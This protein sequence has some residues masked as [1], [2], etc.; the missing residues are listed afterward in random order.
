MAKI[1]K[2]QRYYIFIL[3]NITILF[4]QN[5]KCGTFRETERHWKNKLSK[6]VQTF[7]TRP[8][9]QK[10][11]L[12]TNNKIRIHYDTIGNNQ[13]AMV[14]DFGNRIPNSYNLFI[15]TLVSIVDSVWNAEIDTYGFIAPPADN[16][17]GGGDE[18]DFYIYD[19]QGGTF[20]QTQIEDDL[21][22]GQAKVN[23]Q[24]ASF[25]EMDNDFGVGY[26]TKGVKA[27]MATTAHEF[28]HAIQVGGSGVWDDKYFY[29]YEL[30]AEA[31]ENIVFR[32]AKD[33]IFDISKYFA[34]ISKIPLFQQ[35]LS[36]DDNTIDTPGYERALWGMFLMKKYG[37]EIMKAI[38]DEMKNM[39]PVQS[40]QNALNSF[41]SSL[42]R[43]FADF[44][45]WNYHTGYRS[46]S[47]KYYTD[48]GLFPMVSFNLPVNVTATTRDISFTS[49]SFT[50]NYIKA[51]TN[52]DSAFVMVSNTN[53]VDA[54]NYSQ[55]IFPFKLSF[56]SSSSS[57]LPA[58]SKSIY[59]KL[60]VDDY[61]EWSY[62]AISTT[63]GPLCFPNPFNPLSSSLL[64][65]LQGIQ[66]GSKATLNIYSASSMDL[67][68][69]GTPHY[70]LFSGT[71]YAEWSGR[72]NSGQTASSGIYIFVL[73][74][75]T[76]FNKGKFAIIR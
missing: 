61:S 26:R 8:T 28:H 21:P 1:I 12:T 44:T 23:Q 36:F 72:D 45:F 30:C 62:T 20:G 14:D 10:S 31:M 46:D 49:K 70:K 13:P 18:Y 11:I 9:L 43:E 57:G 2:S 29:F 59:A 7:V 22:V 75:G 58:I 25:I 64:I 69:S 48:A 51:V 68:Y 33:Y 3:L 52:A 35:N 15:D 74:N 17:R 5:D 34:N 27:I 39:P 63:R 38:W 41:S 73:E 65:A 55:Q 24:Y 67:I 16:G 66:S 6:T 40:S 32:D 71:Q 4:A 56:T 50:S 53:F 42:E 76:I 60:I 54:L 47:A 37:T 19:L